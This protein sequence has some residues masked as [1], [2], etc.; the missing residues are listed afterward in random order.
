MEAV[1]KS[2]SGGEGGTVYYTLMA[3]IP[4]VAAIYFKHSGY[5]QTEQTRCKQ[6]LNLHCGALLRGLTTDSLLRFLPWC[7]ATVEGLTPERKADK[8]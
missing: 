3:L 2:W 5:I 4:G 7:S 6:S 1:C 8:T